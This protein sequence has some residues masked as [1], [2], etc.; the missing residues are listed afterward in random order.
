MFES[1]TSLANHKS[2]KKWYALSGILPISRML[3]LKLKMVPS[4][5]NETW[6]MMK[7]PNDLDIEKYRYG[8]I[9]IWPSNDLGLWCTPL[10]PNM[11]LHNLGSGRF[12][13]WDRLTWLQETTATITTVRNGYC[14]VGIIVHEIITTVTF[15]SRW[16]GLESCS[17]NQSIR[18]RLS[19]T[20]P[21]KHCE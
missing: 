4:G 17:L 10:Y 20:S 9:T 6:I 12:T 8:S 7:A 15:H 1:G 3:G 13:C 2:Y 21:C 14:T 18:T 11:I 19:L 16:N 5:V